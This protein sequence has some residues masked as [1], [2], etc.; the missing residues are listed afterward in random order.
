MKSL[1][2]NMHIFL[3]RSLVIV[4][5]ALALVGLITPS[6]FAASSCV[7]ESQASPELTAYYAK[8]DETLSKI[9]IAG[10][11]SSCPVS[12]D[13]SESSSENI[14]RAVQSIKRG[15]NLGLSQDCFASS[16]AFTVDLWLK[17]EV[18]KWLRR[19]LDALI[20]RGDR[21]NSAITNL[22]ATCWDSTSVEIK[23]ILPGSTA[24]D[25]ETL[26]N[27]LTAVLRSHTELVCTYRDI[28]TGR[29]PNINQFLLTPDTFTQDL[30]KSYGAK[31]QEACIVE[32]DVFKNLTE[33]I[34]NIGR[35]AGRIKTSMTVWQSADPKTESESEAR[36]RE[37]RDTKGVESMKK[38]G[39]L[40]DGSDISLRAN[41]T[42]TPTS[43]GDG[44]SGWLSQAGLRM[45]KAIDDIP[46]YYSFAPPVEEAKTTDDWLARYRNLESLKTD[47]AVEITTQFITLRD[48][49]GNEQISKDSYEGKLGSMYTELESGIKLLRQYR[50]VAQKI[51]SQDQ[52]SNEKGSGCE[53]GGN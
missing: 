23:S 1:K 32:G 40:A 37:R 48:Q 47:V 3:N 28:A 41:S 33:A 8:L 20:S 21:I 18:P 26:G 45:S 2:V 12:S 49:I 17:S 16:A 29:I 6:S 19:D 4:P 38:A 30:L 24:N 15:V 31:A 53:P 7:I 39:L 51:C 5:L 11:P 13:G 10:A 46:L 44:I 9:A 25:Q 36:E 50:K 43:G 34:N 27:L 35:T 14:A 22:Y 52:T 42:S